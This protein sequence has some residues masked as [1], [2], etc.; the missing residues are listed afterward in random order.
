[1]MFWK[2]AV[3]W[4]TLLT[5]PLGAG[6]AAE[7]PDAADVALLNRVTWGANE[8]SLSKT[9]ADDPCPFP[10]PRTLRVGEVARALGRQGL[11]I[12]VL[13]VGGPRLGGQGRDVDAQLRAW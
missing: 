2:Q 9:L 3:L 7:A 13:R 5:V 8:A 1:M 11:R 4:G 12:D 10:S 6:Q